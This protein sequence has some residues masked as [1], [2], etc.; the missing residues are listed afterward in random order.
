M[1]TR[2]I[3][4][5]SVAILI[6]LAAYLSL[7]RNGTTPTSPPAAAVPAPETIPAAPAH[8]S[9]MRERV[10]PFYADAES[11]KP[12]PRILPA[13]QFRNYPA[14]ARAYRVAAAMPEVLVQ[15]PCYCWCD[16]FGHGSLLDCFA[17]SHGAG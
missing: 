6:L 14:A 4:L 2:T 12:Y 16:K 17:S 3:L 13:E 1:R 5:L 10:P 7:D 9:P 11:A 15:L 8:P